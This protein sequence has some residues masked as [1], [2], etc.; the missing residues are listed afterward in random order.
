MAWYNSAKDLKKSVQPVA[1]AAGD[2]WSAAVKQP[3]IATAQS[4]QQGS[5][6]PMAQNAANTWGSIKMGAKKAG[7]AVGGLLGQNPQN[8]AGPV[9]GA[10]GEPATYASNKLLLSGVGGDQITQDFGGMISGA[11]NA[12]A[13]KAAIA[14]QYA[15]LGS[16]AKM[17]EGSQRQSEQSAIQRRLAASGM[18]GSGAGMR[19]AGLSEQAAGRR[20]A[21]TQLGLGAEQSAREQA[22]Q[23]AVTGRN[24]QREGMRVG[25]A[26]SAAQRQ[27]NV[28]QATRQGELQTAQFEMDK[29]TTLE[30]QKIAREMQ[31]YNNQ[32]LIGQLGQD[33]FGS[34][35]RKTSMRTPLGALGI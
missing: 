28:Q 5:L 4:I 24:L 3:T 33:I 16:L 13:A 15:Q 1:K 8:Q 10:M 25:A 14:Q 29:A 20:A 23:E 6:K 27:F 17:R 30:N 7:N 22:A 12:D 35:A 2:V 31:R 34:S 21:E 18:G 32:G 9:G 19:L 11:E 26:E